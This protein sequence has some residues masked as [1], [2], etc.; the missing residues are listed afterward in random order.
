M[1]NNKR[2]KKHI[3]LFCKLKKHIHLTSV[4]VNII[5]CK[6]PSSLIKMRGVL[7]TFHFA[8]INSA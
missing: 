1:I 7:C 6:R 4:T 5:L 8:R 2:K 3:P